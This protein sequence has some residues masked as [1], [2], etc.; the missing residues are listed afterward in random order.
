MKGAKVALTTQLKDGDLGVARTNHRGEA[1]FTMLSG[2]YTC[3]ASAIGRGR[4]SLALAVRNEPQ[5]V[6]VQLKRPGEAV[7]VVTDEAGQPIAC[8][9]EFRRSEPASE[10]P[11][12]GPD[13]FAFEVQNLIYSEDGRFRRTLDPGDYELIISHGPEYDAVFQKIAISQGQPIDVKATLVRSVDTT[14][15]VSADFH[16]HSSPSGD[17]TSSQLGRVLN[18]LAEHIEFAPCTEHNRVSS[19][20]PHLRRLRA[21]ERMKSC[22][23]IEL[24]GRDLPINHQNAFPL[25][26][27]PHT[28]DGGGPSTADDPV[29]Q[30][31]R[32]ADWDDGSDKLVQE[33]HPNI[34]R[35]AGDANDDGVADEGFR[36]MF[37]FMDV[38]EVHPPH[39][40]LSP[41][42][43][44]NPDNLFGNQILPWLQLL[45]LGY[46]IPG[47]VNTDAHYTFHGSGFLRNF[48]AS[49]SDDPADIDVMEM[50]H[51]SEHG[52]VVMSNGPFLR[53]DLSADGTT[54]AHIPGDELSLTSGKARLEITVQCANWLDVN[55]V[56]VLLNGRPDQ[57]L[58]F[59]RQTHPEL[60]RTGTERFR[61]SVMLTIAED[62]HVIVATLGEGLGLGPVVGPDHAKDTPV[63]VTNPIFLDVDAN[64]FQA[65][66]DRLGYEMPLPKEEPPSRS[67]RRQH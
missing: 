67:A 17:N 26:H 51:A 10:Q 3:E 25:R 36:G 28:Q 64:G 62:S 8:K 54:K 39:L 23:G 46:R 20:E 33:N 7:V 60:F 41:P 31:Q 45:N 1:T 47:V 37:P 5:T 4:Q 13:T 12:F 14:G 24:T 65:N 59:T 52:H 58:D 66:G 9:V 56:Q 22:P 49:S 29:M 42:E 38:I 35:I 61:H 53:V 30:I 18:L 57:S 6:E 50:V 55:R 32:L 11:Y 34:R 16:S 27:H 63:A 48:V 2:G 15:W 44:S 21:L 40:I 43:E 19:Y